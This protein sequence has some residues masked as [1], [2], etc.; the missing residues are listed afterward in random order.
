MERSVL[1]EQIKNREL[2]KLEDTAFLQEIFDTIKDNPTPETLFEYSSISQLKEHLLENVHS[3]P[4]DHAI[5]SYSV[6]AVCHNK[7]SPDSE[8]LK[9]AI[10]GANNVEEFIENM[11]KISEMFHKDEN[12]VLPHILEPNEDE[13]NNDEGL[14]DE[15]E[16]DV[17]DIELVLNIVNYYRGVHYALASLY[18]EVYSRNEELKKETDAKKKKMLKHDIELLDSIAQK[19]LDEIS[20]EMM[21]ITE[22]MNM[23]S[24]AHEWSAF[25]DDVCVGCDEI[26]MDAE[27]IG[28]LDLEHID[29]EDD[30]SAQI[31]NE[32]SVGQN[33]A[34]SSNGNSSINKEPEE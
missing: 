8:E 1:V 30:N 20:D 11:K 34:L 28:I 6:C 23:V 3:M 5:A 2:K 19:H 27:D 9:W 22:D 17:P 4:D 12:N 10:E 16:M 24:C 15:D 21:S 13:L 31:S 25:V 14:F 7:I 29:E 18:D 26:A 32:F 33:G